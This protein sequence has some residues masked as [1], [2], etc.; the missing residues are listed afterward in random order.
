LEKQ[1]CD[2]VFHFSHL[3][4]DL[5]FAVTIFLKYRVMSSIK[6]AGTGKRF[7]TIIMPLNKADLK[8]TLKKNGWNFKW[9]SECKNMDHQVNQALHRCVW[10]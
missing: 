7:E 10:G 5:N 4:K 6:D 3:S 8:T 2:V 1:V 9:S